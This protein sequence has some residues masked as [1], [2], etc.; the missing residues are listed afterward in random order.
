VGVGNV[1]PSEW[2]GFTHLKQKGKGYNEL[3]TYEDHEV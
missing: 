2:D 1:L 3:K